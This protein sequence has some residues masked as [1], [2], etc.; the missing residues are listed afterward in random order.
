[1]NVNEIDR[2]IDQRKWDVA[3]SF[4]KA[5]KRLDV[6]V[7]TPLTDELCDLIVLETY[8]LLSIRTDRPV[9]YLRESPMTSDLV[10]RECRNYE[11]YV[12]DLTRSP[13]RRSRR[14]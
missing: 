5:L 11:R 12:N 10:Y 13:P 2:Q 6:S 4:A 8:A 7:E 1:M 14:D 3:I 9:W